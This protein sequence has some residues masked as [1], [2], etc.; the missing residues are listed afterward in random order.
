MTAARRRESLWGLGGLTPLRLVRRTWTEMTN[1]E[2]FV[3]AAALTY[4]FVLA[5]FPALLFLISVLGLFAAAGSQLRDGLFQTLAR[6]VPPTATD[7]LSNALN[8]AIQA[9]G[10]GKAA[11]GILAALWAASNGVVAIMQSLN[12]AYEVEEDRPFWKKRAVAVGLTFGLAVLILS[13]AALV[14][15]GGQLA[16]WISQRAG[17]GDTFVTVWNYAQWPVVVAF[18]FLAFSVVYYFAPN[19]KQPDW[20]WI[21]PGAAAGLVLWLA[22][23]FAFRTYLQFFDSYSKTYG[24]LGAV[25]ILMLWLYITGLAVMIGGEVNSEIARAGDERYRRQAKLEAIDRE[26]LGRKAA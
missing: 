3:R 12:V 26:A 25:I 10:G 17:L 22:A 15:F 19:L 7:M 8:E 18:M 5:L 16:G 20:H 2:V 13:A 14:L 23:S 11:F 24:S 4:Y 21:T 1:D 9:S 6:V